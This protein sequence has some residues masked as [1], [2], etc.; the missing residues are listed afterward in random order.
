MSYVRTR[1]RGMGDAA[2]T[3]GQFQTVAGT[4]LGVA[5]PVAGAVASSVASAAAAAG[6]ATPTILGISATAAI[7][8]IGAALAGVTVLATWLIKN[9][10]CGPTCVQATDY[11][12]QSASLMQQNMAAYFA[13]S[14]PRPKSAQA[15]ALANFDAL[16]A[17]LV[18]LCSDPNLGN[19]GKRCISERQP[20]G[21]YDDAK[22]NRDPI[23]NDPNVYDDSQGSLSSAVGALLPAGAGGGSLVPLLALAA[24][25]VVIGVAVL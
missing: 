3:A 13:L 20:G 23:A 6:T 9:S 25:V 21:K 8:I 19:A 7:P 14:A 12:N 18:K 10:G 22:F 5:T 17:Q 1:Y 16:W 11:A 4:A 15:Q 24:L 2:S